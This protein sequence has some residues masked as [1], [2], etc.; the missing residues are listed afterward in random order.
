MMRLRRTSGAVVF[1]ALALGASLAS[2]AS[3]EITEY[4]LKSPPEIGR[5]VRVPNLTGEFGGANCI[6]AIAGNKGYY[7]WKSGAGPEPGFQAATSEPVKLE[8]VKKR[9]VLCTGGSTWSGEY[10]GA[11]NATG[12]K[13][14]L[15]GCTTTDPNT[16]ETL[17]CQTTPPPVGTEGT[18]E[19]S[20]LEQEL[21]LIVGGEKPKVGWDLFRP[22]PPVGA[23]TIVTFECG[24]FPNG[25]KEAI[26]GSVIGRVQRV[27][28]MRFEQ[29]TIYREIAGAQIPEK[30]ESGPK[31]TLLTTFEKGFPTPT[32]EAEEQTGLRTAAVITYKEK[33]EIKSKCVGAC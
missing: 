20:E 32:L 4:N 31:D 5:C 19:G 13:I 14:S 7:N 10:T 3:A 33:L 29:P 12:V 23:P 26:E 21:A 18:I 22:A 24:T 1:A 27:N 2:S 25:I 28:R 16:L 9:I 8:T 6:R 15:S 17:K 30:F 11:K